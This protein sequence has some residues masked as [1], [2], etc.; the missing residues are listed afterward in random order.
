MRVVHVISNTD[1]AA[2]KNIGLGG[3]KQAQ[4][5]I[6]V[7]NVFNRPQVNGFSNLSISNSGFGQINTQ[8]GFMRMTQ[9]MIRFSW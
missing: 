4:V 1:L 2:S 6:E 3:G 7:F 8:G 9:V 5:K